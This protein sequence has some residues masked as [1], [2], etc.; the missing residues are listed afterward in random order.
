[1]NIIPAWH[2]LKLVQ[3]L[4]GIFSVGLSSRTCLLGIL[5]HAIFRLGTFFWDSSL[6]KFRLG[7]LFAVLP[8]NAKMVDGESV[9]VKVVR[10]CMWILSV[11]FCWGWNTCFLYLLPSLL[12]G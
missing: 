2:E 9:P 8:M 5:P 6:G 1:M 10:L 7:S 4:V 3:I 11:A 12:C